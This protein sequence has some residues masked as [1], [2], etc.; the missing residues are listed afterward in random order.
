[1]SIIQISKIQQRAGNLVDL[2]QLDEAEIGF[3]SDA[4]RVFIGKTTSGLENIEVLTSYSDRE[5]MK[6]HLY[7]ASPEEIFKYCKLNFSNNVLLDHSYD[8]YEFTIFVKK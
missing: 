8:L 6:N 7:Y 2:P 4:K 3:A 1:M 5:Y